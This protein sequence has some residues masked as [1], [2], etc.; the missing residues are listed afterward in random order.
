VFGALLGTLALREPFAGA[1]VLG[2]LLIFGGIV[3]I[4]LAA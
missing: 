2:S 4:G 3:A 1:K